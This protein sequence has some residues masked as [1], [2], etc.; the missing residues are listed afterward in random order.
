MTGSHA[1]FALLNRTVNPLVR[2]LLRSPAHGLLSRRLALITVTGR[3]SG[4]I[5]TFPVGYQKEGERVTI[6]LDWPERKRWWRNLSDAAPV[7]VWLAGVRRVGTGRAH[8]DEHAGVTV[9][10]QLDDGA[11]PGPVT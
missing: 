10:I 6:T 7:E 2:A 11:A 4:R 1:P 9:E 8:G 5:F 3:R